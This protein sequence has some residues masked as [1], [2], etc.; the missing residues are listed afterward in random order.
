MFARLF[1]SEHQRDYRK[2][3]VSKFESKIWKKIDLHA[4][5]SCQTTVFERE[6][7]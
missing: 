5:V 2:V 7:R 6:R 1:D 3:L 4:S